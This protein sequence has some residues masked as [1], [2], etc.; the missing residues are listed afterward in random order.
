MDLAVDITSSCRV[1][2]L[3]VPV[4]PIKKSSFWRHVELVRKFNTVRLGDVTPDLHKGANAKFSSQVFQ[5]GQM[6][7]Q[8]VTKYNRDHCHLEDFQ[9]HRRI[10]GVIGIMDC[11]E[12]KD[13]DLSE[14]YKKFVDMLVQYPTAVATRCFAFDPTE[15]QPDDTKGLIMI[16]N[17]GNMSFYMST[18]ICDFASEI[19][20]QFAT[21]AGRIESLKAMESPIF[22]GAFSRRYETLN[23]SIHPQ[24]STSSPSLKSQNQPTNRASQPVPTASVSSSFLKRASS[25][26]GSTRPN[27]SA[28]PPSPKPSLSRSTTFSNLV[29]GGEG[30]KTIQRTPGRIK[31]LLADFYLL[32]GR[33]PDAIQ[34][35]N[36]SIDMTK[37][38]S[39]YL[40]LASA[41]EGLACTMLLMSFLQADVGHIISRNNT[42]DEIAAPSIDTSKPPPIS[43][44]TGLENQKSI[45]SEITEMYEEIVQTYLKVGTTTNIPMPGLVF[46]E[47]C[48]KLSRFLVLV[49]LNNG[50]SDTVLAKIVHADMS[51]LRLQ[52]KDKFLT[53]SDL[54]KCKDSG[55]TRYS[56]ATYVTKIWKVDIDELSM[57]DQVNI[58]THMS[59]VL[60]VIGYHRKSAWFMYETLNRMIP[61]L[62]QGR[63][64]VASSVNKSNV[65]DGGALKILQ[66]KVDE[67]YQN[68]Q[69]KKVNTLGFGWPALQIDILRECIVISEAIQ[70]HASMLYY[71]TVL[72]KN[73]YQ[74]ISKDEQ[75]RLASSI[76]RI[77]NISKRSGQLDN[78]VNYWG[79]NI[80]RSIEPIHPIP[81]KAIYQ[82]PML[83]AKA[84]AA[85]KEGRLNS[86]DPFIYNP[87]A[88]KK[89][90]KPQINL[91]KD[92]TCEFKVSLSN[93]FGFDLELSNIVLSTSGVDFSPIPAAATIP[94]NDT[95]T[96][97][98]M[99]TPMETGSLVIRGCTIK[100]TGFAEQ[101]FLNEKQRTE[102][103]QEKENKVMSLVESKRHKYS[104]LQA[105]YKGPTLDID[106]KNENS[107]ELLYEQI[108]VIEDQ[109]LLKI[110]SSSLLHGAVMLF[111]GEVTRIVIQIENIG[112][113]PVDFITLSFTDSTTNHPKLINPDLPPEEQYEIELY[114]KGTPVFSW[115]GSKSD[116]NQIGKRI[117][118]QPK[119]STDIV[120]NIYGKQGCTGGAVYI[121][122]G[123]LDRA[124][125]G[126]PDGEQSNE[127]PTTLYTRQLYFPVMITVYQ[128]LEPL[129][130][131]VLYLRDNMKVSQEAI[132]KAFESVSKPDAQQWG[133]SDQPV[134]DLLLITQ[135]SFDK[136]DKNPYCLLT[137]DVRN[138][139]NVPFDVDFTIDN[140]EATSDKEILKSHVTIQ[141]AL[142][143]RIV[144]PLKKLFLTAEQ[145]L[146]PVPSFEPNKQFVVS[147]GPKMAPEQERAKLQMFW[148]SELLLERVKASWQCK[149]TG[150]EGVINVRSSLR[151]TPLQ[152]NI[153]KKQDIEFIVSMSDDKYNTG[154]R[155]FECSVNT[156]VTMNVTILNRQVR[157]VKLILRVQAVQSYNDGAKE[158]DLTEKLLMQGVSQLVL[159]E[160]PP[161]G[162]IVHTIPLCFLSIGKFEFL[163]HVEDVHTREIHYDYDWAFVNVIENR[164]A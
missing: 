28:S 114:T 104:G 72:L 81:R 121:D 134:E 11:Q 19:L 97:R 113:I 123:Y 45:L 21:I 61:L 109:P 107:Q 130:W 126:Q 147:Q 83:I 153:L 16:P 35:Y 43:D 137:L 154:H 52:R 33:L 24:P 139:W 76:Q 141:P 22:P 116:S 90:E 152:L 143:K 5:E 17:V 118:L 73:L 37:N 4:S 31:K 132:N 157:P 51:D 3:L 91:I 92:E 78:N 30:N 93:P 150:R 127:L 6:H 12:W 87:F 162:E 84:L 99:G 125:G 80:V 74:Y 41:K 7:F 8:F 105:L 85:S 70:D 50:W 148:Y 158:Y 101:E 66:D 32:A 164:L 129:N 120:V 46:A 14:G 20:D 63:A 29:H 161:N 98:L 110:K 40:W 122:Y 67:G 149:T 2:I 89:N 131:D 144:L 59:T 54:V 58:M 160:I 1:R 124:I 75:I 39:D 57:M 62:I 56:I 119:E 53:M 18:M 23:N 42:S 151:L 94:A 106:S 142:T 49:F 163:Y 69:T 111:E 82:H 79:F 95:L 44:K 145:R 47:S 15:N 108:N 36:E 156:F 48:L 55:I 133:S 60:S 25:A 112:F 77:V 68:Q 10:F 128:H 9:P 102:Q 100:I 65:H 26:A 115:D 159:P 103:V 64:A 86:G 146:Q 96:I 155:Q 117:S 135:K 136:N 13:K 88:K 27:V 140:T 34:F 138:T 38:H 71:T